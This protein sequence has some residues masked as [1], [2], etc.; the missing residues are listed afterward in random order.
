MSFVEL[1]VAPGYARGGDDP[2]CGVDAGPLV[3]VAPVGAAA[4]VSSGAVD[5]T[6]VD[7]AGG[8]GWRHR[9]SFAVAGKHEV[10]AG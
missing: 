9:R 1:S 2:P 5:E 4:K 7:A 3:D 6:P 10:P 8:G